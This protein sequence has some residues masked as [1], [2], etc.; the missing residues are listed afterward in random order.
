MFLR[1]VQGTAIRNIF[2]VLKDIINDVNIY[3]DEN[4]LTIVTLDMARASLI[5]LHLNSEN[6]EEYRCPSKIVAGM[7]MFN[8][9]KLLKSVGANDIVDLSIETPEFINIHIQN[10]IKKSLTKFDL[11][12]LDINEDI[13]VLPEIVMDV[14]T[15]LPSADFQRI[16]RDMGNIASEID[17]YREGSFLNL[18]CNGDFANQKTVMDCQ[19]L[20]TKKIGNTFSLKYLNLF[21]KATGMSSSVQILQN[22]TNSDMPI[23]LRYSIANLGEI[24]FY[25]A[26]KTDC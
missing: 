14:T 15:T 23:V 8:M 3:F 7:N 1:T 11:K 12:L 26:P 22:S 5:H 24:K 2:E 25:L 20:V 6:F 19:S 13:L 4:G 18:E 21:T 10:Q 16:C 9:Y 17:I